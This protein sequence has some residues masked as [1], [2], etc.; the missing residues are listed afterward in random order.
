MAV[1]LSEA[2]SI[3]VRAPAGNTAL[4][5]AADALNACESAAFDMGRP[6]VLSASDW[7]WVH[8]FYY[9][10]TR[11][12]AHALLQQH[13]D[14]GFSHAVYDEQT[15][16]WSVKLDNQF[17]VGLGHIYGDNAFD[18]AR[19]EVWYWNELEFV[20]AY[21]PTSDM[22]DGQTSNN[23]GFAST[24]QHD[25]QNGM[26]FH[27][28]LYGRSDGGLVCMHRNNGVYA[29]RRS[30]DSWQQLGDQSR[31]WREGVGV[32]CPVNDVGYLGGGRGGRDEPL[33]MRIEPSSTTP[34][35]T[36]LPT[37][38]VSPQGQGA[39]L[40]I[41]PNLTGN[42]LLLGTA[43][44]VFVSSDQGNS[45]APHMCGTHPFMFAAGTPLVCSIPEYGVVWGLQ[46][47]T[48]VLWKPPA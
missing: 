26:L 44:E 22:W 32:Y 27:P 25:R 40:V 1:S 31:V 38:P 19:G 47:D 14:Q 39:N 4:A 17:T 20:R 11:Q 33:F 15:A 2:F 34:T 3:S 8:E 12:V 45:W 21:R 10:P 48:S 9:D 41:D 13:G 23:A 18:R 29:W 42:I 35:V 16:T 5:R 37:P 6:G 28:N 24:Q 46:W 30:T 7:D 36:V 43:G